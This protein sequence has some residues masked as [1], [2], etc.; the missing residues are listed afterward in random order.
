MKHA[1]WLRLVFRVVGVLL[2]AL[3][4]PTVASLITGIVSA[5]WNQM[6][7]DPLNA[8]AHSWLAYAVGVFVASIGA[9]AQLALGLY[10]FI[11][12]RWLMKVCID[13][14]TYR[15]PACRADLRGVTAPLACPTCGVRLPGDIPPGPLSGSP[16]GSQNPS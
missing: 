5:F 6:R 1:P 3:S 14:I 7:A 2:I 16:S 11:N 8:P 15:C 10:L 9:L 12:P 13:D 4:L